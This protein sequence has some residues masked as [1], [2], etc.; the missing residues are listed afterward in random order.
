MD[1]EDIG[2]T[3]YK[4][5]THVLCLPGAPSSVTQLVGAIGALK[6]VFGAFFESLRI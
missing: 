2:P 4:C 5:Y 1:V 6:E 3:L